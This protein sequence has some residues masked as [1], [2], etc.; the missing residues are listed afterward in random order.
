MQTKF[1]VSFISKLCG[2]S[3]GF[4]IC[5]L[6]TFANPSWKF[7]SGKKKEHFRIQMFFAFCHEPNHS[8]KENQRNTFFREVNNSYM[9]PP[10]ETS[11]LSK[12]KIPVNLTNLTSFGSKLMFFSL[13]HGKSFPF[14]LTR[15]RKT[16]FILLFK[17]FVKIRDL[18]SIKLILWIFFCWKIRSEL[19]KFTYYQTFSWK[20]RHKENH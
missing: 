12:L 1:G 2:S 3:S 19:R 14:A 9:W 10:S 15:L 8:W 13:I 11:N 16:I 6:C 4:G 18:L 20:Q 7:V 17:Y 5:L